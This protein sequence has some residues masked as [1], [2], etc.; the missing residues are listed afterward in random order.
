MNN[1][2]INNLAN[3]EFMLYGSRSGMNMN[4][5]SVY[6][7]YY[8]PNSVFGNPYGMYAQSKNPTF[9]GYNNTGFGQ[10]I[11][12]NY[13]QNTGSQTQ[14]ENTS[15]QQGITQEDMDKLADYYAKNNVLEEGFTGALTGGLSWMAFEH[16][17]SIFHPKNATRGVKAA[18]AIFKNVPKEFAKTNAALLQEAQIAVQ[19][20]VRDS[21]DKGWWS[22]WLR[23]P[24]YID[25]PEKIAK[26]DAAARQINQANKAEVTRELNAMKKAVENAV[27]TGNVKGIAE[28]TARL[29]AARGMDGRIAGA[30][31][32]RKTVAE[33]LK[34]KADTIL[35]D[36]NNL[37]SMNKSVITKNFG[38]LVKSSFK[39]DFV[40]FMIFETIFNAGKIMTAFQKDTKTCVEQTT[41]SLGKSAL[42]T[43]GWCLG[44][45]AGTWLGAKAGAAI[46]SMICP[47][48]GTAVGALIG[49][50]VGSV[51]M[52]AGHKL[53][54][55][56]FG[57]D[58][59]DKVEAQEMAKTREGQTE[60]LQ[61]AVQKAQEGKTDAGTNKIVYKALNAYA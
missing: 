56:I 50:T 42:G 1:F 49:F 14:S 23:K 18:N 28:A 26:M 13:V 51:G 55:K 58:V 17:Q 16:A 53:G 3:M 35:K 11:P 37:V 5:P 54:N 43:A 4:C 60:L 44:R 48:A 31:T 40:G 59:A 2:A 8:V 52:W 30:L 9:N 12:S 21:G 24:L 45:A 25:N 29:Q 15:F 7:G 6:N 19:Q 22:K 33:R 36:K 41:Q 20:V 10:N 38:E 27:R 61:F 47:G 57:T 39:K 46:G 34:S 32:G